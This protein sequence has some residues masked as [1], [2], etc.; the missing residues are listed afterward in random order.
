MREILDGH[1]SF[2]GG[3]FYFQMYSY[4]WLVGYRL[5]LSDWTSLICPAISLAVVWTAPAITFHSPSYLAR[6]YRLWTVIL[7]NERNRP[8]SG[9]T[10]WKPDRS[11]G[12]INFDLCYFFYVVRLS[13]LCHKL[14]FS[15][16][17]QFLTP[18]YFSFGRLSPMSTVLTLLDPTRELQI[19]NWRGL[20]F[21]IMKPAVENMYLG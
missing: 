14:F 17:C 8:S 7:Q 19:Y 10:M 6:V 11:K 13:I 4:L 12:N 9:R 16:N 21:I 3:F 20:T 15:S 5:L 2:I 1:R 18:F